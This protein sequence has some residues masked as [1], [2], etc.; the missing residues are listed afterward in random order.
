MIRVIADDSKTIDEV[1]KKVY[2][3]QDKIKYKA[4]GKTRIKKRKV[5]K[6]QKV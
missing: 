1:I 5:N 4:F 6:L 2:K 3:I